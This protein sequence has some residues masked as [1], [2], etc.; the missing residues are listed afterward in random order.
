MSL[1]EA[2]FLA[3]FCMCCS[4]AA[5]GNVVWYS[6]DDHDTYAGYINRRE[7]YLGI[8]IKLDNTTNSGIQAS[9]AVSVVV[10]SRLLM[11]EAC[12]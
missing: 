1:V 9:I 10:G 2:C 4:S 3:L 12:R 8:D 11:E 5:G 6:G 7:G